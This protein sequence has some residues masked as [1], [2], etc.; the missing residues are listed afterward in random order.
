MK[1]PEEEFEQSELFGEYPIIPQWE[2]IAD[3][4]LIDEHL[5]ETSE[6]SSYRQP[7][8]FHEDFLDGFI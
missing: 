2:A 7:Q 3:R 4:F 6:V 8:G 1:I 5:P